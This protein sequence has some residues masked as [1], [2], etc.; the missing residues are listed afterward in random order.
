MEKVRTQAQA[1]DKIV[2]FVAEFSALSSWSS[3]IA[4]PTPPSAHACC[5]ST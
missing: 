1:V 4:R 5:T 3:C 2:E